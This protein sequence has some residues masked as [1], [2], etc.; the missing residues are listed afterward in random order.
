AILSP[1]KRTITS[2]LRVMGLG[3]DHG[4]A[5]YRHVLNRAVFSPLQLSR[6]LLLLLVQHLGQGDEPM[7]FGID[8]TIVRR[9]GRRISALGVYRDAVRSSDSHVVKTTGLR[10]TCPRV[11]WTRRAARTSTAISTGWSWVNPSI[12]TPAATTPSSASV[13]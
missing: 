4:F 5:K 1:R 2:A 10:W 8:E 13:F 9:R 3:S 6:V 7:V 12:W 11:C